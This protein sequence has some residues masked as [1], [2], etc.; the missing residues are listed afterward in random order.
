L[1]HK[2]PHKSDELTD[3]S[4]LPDHNVKKK[5]VLRAVSR[6]LVIWIGQT[7][8]GLQQLSM[9]TDATSNFILKTRSSKV[10]QKPRCY[11]ALSARCMQNDTH[12]LM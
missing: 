8:Q 3:E 1:S 11:L 4:V 6:T 12:F 7:H 5:D 2:S 9:D 10:T